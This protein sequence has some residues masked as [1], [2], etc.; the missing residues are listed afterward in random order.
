[1]LISL[2]TIKVQLMC[3]VNQSMHWLKRYSGGRKLHLAALPIF[4]CL[5]VCTWKKHIDNLWWIGEREWSWEHSF[6]DGALVNVNHIKQARY[7]LQVSIA[8]IFPKL[9]EAH[10][11]SG[12]NLRLMDWL[13]EEAKSHTMCFY[14]KLTLCLQLDI[15]VFLRSIREKNF[16]FYVLLIEKLI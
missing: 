7:C 10:G 8:V 12:S 11:A 1:M 3:A 16:H 13:A 6:C 9:K 2:T 15:L 14:W 4:H 5:G